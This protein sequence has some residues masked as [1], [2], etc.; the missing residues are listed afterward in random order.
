MKTLKQV[1]VEP[2]YVG[3]MPEVLE[4]GK[5][6]ISHQFSTTSHLCLCGCGGLTVLPLNN[7]AH[8]SHG[9]NLEEHADGSISFTPSIFNKIFN[10]R[11]HYV[12]TKSKANILEV[13]PYDKEIPDSYEHSQPGE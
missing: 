6:Y 9:W 2:V 7:E 5:I 1:E 10:C 4:Q 3:F 11:A 12:I 13:Y 8:P